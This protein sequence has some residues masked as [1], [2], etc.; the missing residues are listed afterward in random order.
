MEGR[1]TG[2]GNGTAS[3]WPPASG[4]LLAVDNT[5]EIVKVEAV[6]TG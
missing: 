5:A 1:E 3:Q 2:I 4:N 6:Q